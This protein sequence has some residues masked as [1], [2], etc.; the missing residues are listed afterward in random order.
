MRHQLQLHESR[1]RRVTN[2]I[3]QG[4]RVDWKDETEV[5]DL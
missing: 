2:G 4:E 3:A 1:T 5:I